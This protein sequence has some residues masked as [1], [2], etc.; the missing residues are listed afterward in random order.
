MRL[1]YLLDNS[2]CQNHYRVI[3]GMSKAH[4]INDPIVI[5][6]KTYFIAP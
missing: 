1:M 3:D 6:A 2:G 4:A 5:L